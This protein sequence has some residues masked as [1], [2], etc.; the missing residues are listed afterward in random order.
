METQFD[1]RQYVQQLDDGRWIVAAYDEQHNQWYCPMTA[2]EQRVPGCHTYIA[3]RLE[4][5]GG[6]TFSATV[7]FSSVSWARYTT[8]MPPTPTRLSVR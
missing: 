3:H 6:S 1:A 7:R 8:P 5:L 2:E 4:D